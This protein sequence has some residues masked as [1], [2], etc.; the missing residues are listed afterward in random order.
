MV[1]LDGSVVAKLKKK[2]GYFSF[3][4]MRPCPLGIAIVTVEIITLMLAFVL[5]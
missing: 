2:S 5:S 4:K 3:S 1:N